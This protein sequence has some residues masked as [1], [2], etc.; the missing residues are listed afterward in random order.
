MTEAVKP[1][2]RDAA[3]RG[4]WKEKLRDR[5]RQSIQEQGAFGVR[6][7]AIWLKAYKRAERSVKRDQPTVATL[8]KCI[9]QL[10]DCLTW[11]ST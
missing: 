6:Q 7:T 11:E 2:P 8:K 1:P 5:M 4:E 10:D 9:T 3:K